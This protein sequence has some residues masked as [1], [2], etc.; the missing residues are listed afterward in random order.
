MKKWVK[1]LLSVVAVIILTIS[2]VF[3]FTA[4]MVD[5]ADAFFMAV[6]EKDMVKARTYL[7]EDFKA[8]TND[9]A[10]TEF[11]SSNALLNFKES[12]WS[13]RQVNDDGRG[14]LNGSITTET[15]GLVPIKMTFVKEK[16]E[17]KIYAIEKPAAG[18]QT[19]STTTAA[20]T[21]NSGSVSSGTGIPDKAQQ[22]AMVKQAMHDFLISVAKKD[23]THFRNTVSELWQKQFT[24]EMLNQGFKQIIDSDANWGVLEKEEPILTAEVKADKDGVIVLSG[25][26][27]TKPSQVKFEQ[28]YIQ[29]GNVWKLISLSVEATPAAETSTTTSAIP[30]KA[31]QTAMVKQ[32]MH[33]F[34]V[35]VAKK[36]MTHF[37]STVSALWQE[38]F[39][40]ERF[41]ATYKAISDSDGNW[42]VLENLQP[43]L[44]SEVKADE[45][46]VIVLSGNYPTKPNQVTFEQKYIQEGNVWK[47]VGFSIQAK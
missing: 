45:N 36:D 2:L 34:L 5:A 31:Q 40:V 29:E 33:D 11:L 41:N 12:S 43:A 44:T 35:S 27:A 25:Y 3:Y 15:G 8:N 6:K 10:L 38:Q 47:L 39:T 14:E 30:D 23:M 9:K 21:A 24:V 28:K 42:S 13:D 4:G 7:A 37:R 17:W 1:I 18:L 22:T 26:Y 16:D 46:G 32:A 19:E 20:S